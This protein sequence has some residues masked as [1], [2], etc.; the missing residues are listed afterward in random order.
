M[1]NMEI[2]RSIRVHRRLR[3]IQSSIRDKMLREIRASTILSSQL[4]KIGGS[5][6][7]YLWFVWIF[8]TAMGRRQ[9]SV[10]WDYFTK[11]TVSDG[12]KKKHFATCQICD[13]DTKFS[14]NTTNQLN[15]LRIHHQD[16]YKLIE[17][18]IHKPPKKSRSNGNQAPGGLLIWITQ[19]TG[20]ALV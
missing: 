4:M 19:K 16:V 3:R 14:Q 1:K 12:P 5:L 15:H 13:T 17:T 10:V 20:W 8:F 2:N 6:L 11:K 9:T 18:E 7:V